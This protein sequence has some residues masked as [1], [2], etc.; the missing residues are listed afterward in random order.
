MARTSFHLKWGCWL[1][2][3]LSRGCQ[4]IGGAAVGEGGKLQLSG[5]LKVGASR[6]KLSI[7]E[8]AASMLAGSMLG[9]AQA[10][11]PILAAL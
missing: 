2:I 7:D 10:L 8:E 11:R 1:T 4:G 9:Q 3:G 6:A 5:H